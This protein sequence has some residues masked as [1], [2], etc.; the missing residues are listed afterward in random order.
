MLVIDD[1]HW[2]DAASL[3]FLLYLAR[4]RAGLRVA[5]LIGARSDE[6][7]PAAVLDRI[8]AE[9]GVEVIE[10]PVLTV[11]AATA[12]AG[13]RAGGT[14]APDAARAAH[15]VTGGNPFFLGEIGDALAAPPPMPRARSR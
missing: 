14:P 7:D 15:E 2:A 4:R 10:P 5:V 6:P 12:A 13:Q 9:P 11:A 3:Q 1:A 8:L